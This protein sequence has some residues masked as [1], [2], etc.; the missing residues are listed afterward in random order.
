MKIYLIRHGQTDWNVQGRIQGRENVP[1]SE[2]GIGQAD[3]AGRTL[4]G[5][6]L[7]EIWSSPLSRAVDTAEG[8]AK[9][10]PVPIFTDVRLT[11]RDF[12]EVSGRRVDI[13]NPG[14]NAKG[15]EPLDDVSTRMISAITECAA[16]AGGDF[17][18]VSH[19]GAINAVL[20]TVSCGEIGSGKTRLKNTGICVFSW[21]GE[22]LELLDH[23][24][25]PEEFR[26][27]YLD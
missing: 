6:K 3:S 12:G 16:K 2:E 21:D 7:A 22:T 4:R 11:E 9:Y 24:L 18:V 1:L 13:F 17:A 5:L 14:E 10:I 19:G 26:D 8:I 27:K 20:R 23:N 25:S 15:M